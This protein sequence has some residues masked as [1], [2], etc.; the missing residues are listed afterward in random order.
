MFFL[1]MTYREQGN[2]VMVTEMQLIT[3]LEVTAIV[4]VVISSFFQCNSNGN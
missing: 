4:M 2:V 3:N 1:H